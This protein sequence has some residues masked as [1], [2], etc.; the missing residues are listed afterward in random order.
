MI[1]RKLISCNAIPDI[2][3]PPRMD[4]KTK[5]PNWGYYPITFNSEETQK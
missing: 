2:N 4:E 5:R 3:K 1:I